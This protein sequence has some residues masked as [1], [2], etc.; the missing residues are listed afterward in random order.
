MTAAHAERSRQPGTVVVRG[1]H[2]LRL[3]AIVH[4]LAKAPSWREEW[5]ASAL[6]AVFAEV[7]ARRLGSL[8]LPPLGCVHGRLPPAVF[9]ALLRD[10]LARS[11]PPT[12]RELWLIGDPSLE[13]LS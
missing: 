3:L 5:V 6:D 13:R 8:G 10:A 12:L 7:A 11:R 4:D 1:G 2:P 9:G